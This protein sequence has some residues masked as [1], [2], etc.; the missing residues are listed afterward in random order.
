M[1]PPKSPTTIHLRNKRVPTEQWEAIRP[2]FTRLYQEEKRPLKEVMEILE[3][4]HHFKATY[5]FP[6]PAHP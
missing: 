3:R 4:E 2:L 1:P 6:N 5:V